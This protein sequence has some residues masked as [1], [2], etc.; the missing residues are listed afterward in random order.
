MD[1]TSRSAQEGTLSIGDL[2][3]R[4]GVAPATLRMW[5]QRHG[6]PVPMRLASGHRRYRATDVVVVE[7]VLRRR[8][9]GVRLDIAIEQA[10]ARFL[11]QARPAPSSVFAELGRRHPQLAAHRL[12]KTSLIALSWAIE[13]EFCAKATRP[14]LFGAF[15]RPEFYAPSLPR[16]RELAR[17]AR[18]AHVFADF[19]G[20]DP[21]APGDSTGPVEVAL[22][23]DAPLRREWV[24]VCDS[25]EL[26]A[27][28]AAWELPGQDDVPDRDRVFEAVWTV[29]PEAVRD[30]ARVCA[31]MARHA[32]APD[33]ASVADELAAPVHQV[34]ADLGAVTTL[35]N[36]VVAYGDAVSWRDRQRSRRRAGQD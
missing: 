34:R 10:V 21:V 1:M 24:V 28:L 17:V 3:Q 25:A 19:A 30:A 29:D 13:D 2:A 7:D 15:Q 18:S 8:E 27:A 20:S 16:W 11:E 22:A 26:S 32:G 33:A 9:E 35:F 4:T 6:F 23:G 5:E 14:H 36:R 12:R 31:A